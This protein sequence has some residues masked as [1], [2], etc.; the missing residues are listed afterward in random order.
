MPPRPMPSGPDYVADAVAL[1]VDAQMIDR[2]V[3]HFYAEVRRDALLGPI[4]EARIADWAPHLLRMNAFW[5]SVM[6]RSGDY[7]GQPMPMHVRL[8]VDASHFDRW[9][10]LF[11]QAAHSI[12]GAAAP[13]FIDRAH[14]IAQS[15]ELGVAGA[16]GLILRSDERLPAIATKRADSL[17]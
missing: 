17:S 6:L 5:S 2:L 3:Q 14:R 15:L 16:R 12:C 9:L 13:L 1:G 4:F 7:H 10:A 8:P 11:E